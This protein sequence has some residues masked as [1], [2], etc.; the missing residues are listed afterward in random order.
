MKE[1]IE[2]LRKVL[3]KQLWL[4]WNSGFLFDESAY[5][6]KTI[7]NQ[8]N[9]IISVQLQGLLTGIALIR[10]ARQKK[11]PI[12]NKFHQNMPEVFFMFKMICET[13]TETEIFNSNAPFFNFY[14]NFLKTSVIHK[15][16]K[17][18]KPILETSTL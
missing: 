13:S 9:N 18:I 7:T 10:P 17:K 1:S 4:T 16:R 2:S 14:P 5:Q 11:N 8:S 12:Y 15:M 3:G 6:C